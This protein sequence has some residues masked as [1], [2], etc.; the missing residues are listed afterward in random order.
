M[1]PSMTDAEL[2]RMV[3]LEVDAQHLACKESPKPAPIQEREL[4][5][6]ELDEE[7]GATYSPRW[8]GAL[9]ATTE[10]KI[11]FL[12]GVY[13][14][15]AARLIEIQRRRR[16]WTGY[17]LRTR[18][19][20]PLGC[21]LKT[22][23]GSQSEVVWGDPSP[24]RLKSGRP[25]KRHNR[26][27]NAWRGSDRRPHILSSSQGDHPTM[28]S[29]FS[30][31]ALPPPSVAMEQLQTRIRACEEKFDDASRRAEAQLKLLASLAS[32]QSLRPSD[33]RTAPEFL[34]LLVA[35]TGRGRSRT[36]GDCR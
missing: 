20:R 5:R 28:D 32:L 34:V 26:N 9:A 2:D 15:E 21:I 16:R 8:F 19:E 11:R 1:I 22:L 12:R 13:R 36:A 10:A 31:R 35:T 7:F 18:G 30:T 17:D 27:L 3:L 24:A 6:W 4:A 23:S 29:H 25:G 33:T 14:L